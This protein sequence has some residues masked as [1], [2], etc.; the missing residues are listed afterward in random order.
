MQPEESA[1][2]AGFRQYAYPCSRST[3]NALET[4]RKVYQDG[5]VL[6]HLAI[7]SR[8]RRHGRQLRLGIGE[9][10]PVYGFEGM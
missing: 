8:V 3:K 10:I 5:V 4:P 7:P 6:R 2:Q 1:Q 9:P